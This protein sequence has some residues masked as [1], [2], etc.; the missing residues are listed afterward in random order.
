M[1]RNRW[2]TSEETLFSPASLDVAVRD[3]RIPVNLARGARLPRNIARA[4]RYLSH[5]QVHNLAAASGKHEALVLLLSYTGLRWGEVI[6][7]RVPCV[8][9]ARRRLALSATPSQSAKR[10]SPGR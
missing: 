1:N 8:D 7:L 10:P 2:A 3:R 4:H 9:R 6:A 5:Q